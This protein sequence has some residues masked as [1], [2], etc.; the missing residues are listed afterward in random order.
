MKLS[1]VSGFFRITLI[2]P[3]ARGML[4]FSAAIAKLVLMVFP[5]SSPPVIEAIINGKDIFLLKKLTEVFI[6]LRSIS[7]SALWGRTYLSK[8]EGYGCVSFSKTIFI[9]CNFLCLIDILFCLFSDTKFSDCCNLYR[10][11]IILCLFNFFCDFV[12]CDYYIIITCD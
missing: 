9:C 7:G 10:S 3:S 6:S 11:W 4:F 1:S 8:E 5:N 2:D 12:C